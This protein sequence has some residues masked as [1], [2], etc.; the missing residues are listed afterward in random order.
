MSSRSI[1]VVR[2]GRISC[3]IMAE[4]YSIVCVCACINT[5]TLHPLYHLSVDRYLGYFHILIIVNNAALNTGVEI[6]LQYL[7]YSSFR[8]IPKDLTAASY[9][10]SVFDFSRNLLTVLHSNCSFPAAFPSTVHERPF[11]FI[12][13]PTPAISP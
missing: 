6:S 1:R 12:P 2:N 9:A 7:V 13:S 10:R 5:Y 4:K 8:C 3:S 11:F